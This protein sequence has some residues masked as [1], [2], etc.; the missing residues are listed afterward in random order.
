MSA[1]LRDKDA[2]LSSS[3]SAHMIPHIKDSAPEKLKTKRAKNEGSAEITDTATTTTTLKGNHQKSSSSSS[4]T[5]LSSMNVVDTMS[6]ERLEG[7]RSALA[8]AEE[9]A[10]TLIYSDG[11]SLLRKP[12]PVWHHGTNVWGIVETT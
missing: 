4:T 2:F 9:V 6:E 1:P 3:S 8:E 12:Q 5:S 10:M 11:S 7:V